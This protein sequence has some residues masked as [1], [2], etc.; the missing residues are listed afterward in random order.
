MLVTQYTH[1]LPA[2]YDMARIRQRAA[3]RGPD[4]DSFPGLIFKGFLIQEKGRL[5]AIGNA[6][7]SLYLWSGAD[8]FAAMIAG[9]RFKAVMDTFGRPSVETFIVLA[10]AFVPA[11]DAAFV[12]RADE[13][14]PAEADLAALK[15][16]EVKAAQEIARSGEIFAAITALDVSGWRVSRFVLSSVAAENVL[17]LAG[18]YDIAHLAK[19]S[20]WHAFR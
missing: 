13:L 17:P 14:V 8:A 2:D 16:R 19:P 20:Q 3:S 9:D 18:R 11:R 4:W 15:E 6:Y 1:R 5:G 10:S 7:S 12:H